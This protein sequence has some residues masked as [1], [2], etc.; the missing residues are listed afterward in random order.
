MT[1]RRIDLKQQYPRGTQVT[2]SSPPAPR[3][4]NINLSTIPDSQ[5][6]ERLARTINKRFVRRP[7]ITISLYFSSQ[8]FAF[9]TLTDYFQID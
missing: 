8:L 9:V 5:P 7:H 1:E 6:I 2:I 3:G 4:V